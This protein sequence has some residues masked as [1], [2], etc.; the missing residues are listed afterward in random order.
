VA[1]PK[2]KR[3]RA[4]YPSQVSYDERQRESGLCR[5]SV[6]VHESNRNKLIRTAKRLTTPAGAGG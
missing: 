2:E 4:K 5:V 3:N 6:W 1:K